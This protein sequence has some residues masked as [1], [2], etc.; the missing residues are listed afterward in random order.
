MKCVCFNQ[1]DRGRQVHT[2][3]HPHTHKGGG[4]HK[5]THILQKGHKDWHTKTGTCRGRDTY[6]GRAIERKRARHK[7][8]KET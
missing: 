3:M 7:G 8:E 6:R 2:H 5:E 4:T 1:L